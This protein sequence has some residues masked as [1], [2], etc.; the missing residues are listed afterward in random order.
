MAPAGAPDDVVRAA[1]ESGQSF[2]DVAK[3]FSID[4]ASKSQGGK[5]PAVAQGQQE[6]AKI[7]VVKPS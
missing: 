5:L 7:D 6:K 4:E 3:E 1:L 2:E